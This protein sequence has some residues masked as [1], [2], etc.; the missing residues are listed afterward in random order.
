MLK[1]G[2]YRKLA[3][4]TLIA[5]LV[6]VLVNF[7]YLVFLMVS[8]PSSPQSAEPAR[9]RTEQVATPTPPP[10]PTPVGQ[11]DVSLRPDDEPAEVMDADSLKGAI[12]IREESMTKMSR[13]RSNEQMTQQMWARFMGIELVYIFAVALVMLSVMTDTRRHRYNSY[14]LRLLLCVALLVIFF[15]IAPQLT[16]RGYIVT[17]LNSGHLFFNPMSILKLAATFLVAI[18]YGKIYELLYKKQEMEVENE[19][20]KNE[21]LTWQYNT[22]VNQV[23]PHF[24]FNSL[25][26]L[27]MLVR[28]GDTQAAQTYIDRMSQTYRY[29]ISDGN[30]ELTT[31]A[32]ELQFVDAYRYLLEVR[33]AGKLHINIEVPE[34]YHAYTL[35]A[36]SIQPLIENAVKHNTITTAQPMN[37]TIS[38]GEG[39]IVVS[40][41]I[42]PKIEPEKGTGIGLDNLANRY[43]LICGSKITVEQTEGNFVVKLPIRQ[44]K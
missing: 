12:I 6:S 10:S 24:L 30:N 35:P 29:I 18:L 39:H 2:R 37:I 1:R 14:F 31:V 9:P 40:N 13:H 23:N 28:E 38:A 8:R 25:N 11:G 43:E 3:A 16:W 26:S 7:S 33:Y 36:L 17:T 42:R 27:A 44:P 15:L 34:V 32:D 21:S 4:N 20:L 5:I 22:L 19:R 41:P